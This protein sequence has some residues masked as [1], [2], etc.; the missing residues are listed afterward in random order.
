MDKII[1]TFSYN[2]VCLQFHEK[3]HPVVLLYIRFFTDLIKILCMLQLIFQLI[4][5]KMDANNFS[6]VR[7]T[8]L[9]RILWVYIF[10][11]IK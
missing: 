4:L 6:Q 7:D 1:E 8:V 9:A 2:S 3:I 5:V 11:N 10:N